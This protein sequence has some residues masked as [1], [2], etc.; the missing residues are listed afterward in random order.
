MIA[1]VSKALRVDCDCLDITGHWPQN[2]FEFENYNWQLNHNNFGIL[3]LISNY[4]YYYNLF[5]YYLFGK[6]SNK[7]LLLLVSSRL[8]SEALFQNY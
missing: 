8:V 1:I 2:Q 6:F 4:Y 5:W 3:F 7:M